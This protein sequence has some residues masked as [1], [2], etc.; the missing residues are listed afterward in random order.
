MDMRCKRWKCEDC[1]PWLKWRLVQA[2][3]GAVEE[4]PQL[5]RF[6]TLTL[7]G[8]ARRFS[9]ERRYELLQHAWTKLARRLDRRL[10]GGFQYIKVVEPHKDGTPHIHGLAARFIPVSLLSALWG[11]CGGGMVDIRFVDPQRVAAYL[12]KY[13]AK[14]V[15]APP[16]G[17][18]KYSTGGG[19]SLAGVRPPAGGGEWIVEIHTGGRFDWMAPFD[20]GADIARLQAAQLRAARPPDDLASSLQLAVAAAWAP[21]R[22][23]A[24]QVELQDPIHVRQLRPLKG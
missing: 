21:A 10:P 18:R 8:E 9:L 3:E 12:A 15:G 4:L 11:E 1:G 14:H 20:V 17:M 24:H 13:M 16:R 19:V 5:R 2:I 6:F 7:T 22:R 23:R